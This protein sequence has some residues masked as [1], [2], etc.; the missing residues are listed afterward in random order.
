MTD[1][2]T[3]VHDYW[4]GRSPEYR[5]MFRDSIGEEI[6][7]MK[8][9][10][11]GFLPED[12]ENIR[13][14]DIGTGHGIQAFTFAEMG[15][16]VSAVDLS[17]E[18]LGRA[19]A[20][21]DK[22]GLKIDFSHGDAEKLP[23]DDNSFDIIINMHLL[24][25]LT[26][27]DLFFRECRR[28]IV[29]GGRIISIDGQWFR[30]GEPDSEDCPDEIRDCIPLYHGNTPEKISGLMRTNGFLDV[31]WKYLPEYGEY[32]RRCDCTSASEY[33][34]TPYLVTSVKIS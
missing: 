14:L 3:K 29:P 4:N 30:P 34:A 19:G 10:L 22:R 27:H 20:E 17:E 33:C 23:F 8:G 11:T 2:K 28:V 26:D 15:C 1:K 31:S 7:M 24:W 25:T 16:K 21:A 13:V 9:Y 12:T 18:M 5:K 32:M 6:A